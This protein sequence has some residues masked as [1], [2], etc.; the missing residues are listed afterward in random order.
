MPT[1][2]GID[3]VHGYKMFGKGIDAQG[4]YYNV[5]YQIGDWENADA[6]SNALVGVDDSSPHRHPLSTNLICTEA[7]PVGIGRPVL[8]ADGYPSYD[9]G[10]V[11]RAVYR[12]AGSA[13]FGGF[14]DPAIDD[15]GSAHQIDPT[16]PIAWC[17]QELDFTVESSSVPGSGYIWESDSTDATVPIQQDVNVTILNLTFERRRALPMSV[18]RAKRGRINSSTF[19]GAPAECVWFVGA[20]STRTPYTD[21]SVTQRVQLTFKERD[22]SWNKFLRPGRM[23]SAAGSW[24]YL[25]DIATNRRFLTTDLSPLVDLL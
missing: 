12:S 10:A 16:T 3:Y 14:P 2:A 19:L 1:L 15:P 11:I 24:D 21:G 25:Q 22:V 20:K 9:R 6:F 17:T 5:E 18:V 13:F 23:P 8:N 7:I 4:P